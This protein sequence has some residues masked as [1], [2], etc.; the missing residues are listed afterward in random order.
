MRLAIEV[1][2]ARARVEQE[3]DV[4]RILP[5][6]VAVPHER[7]GRTARRA[8]RE[9]LDVLG[10]GSGSFEVRRELRCLGARPRLERHLTI[11]RIAD[12]ARR[13]LRG[14]AGPRGRARGGPSSG[15]PPCGS[16]KLLWL[17]IVFDQC[18]WTSGCPSGSRAPV[19]SPG[20]DHHARVRSRNC[21][22]P[23]AS[24]ERRRQDERQ[25]AAPAARRRV[26]SMTVCISGSCGP[27]AA[28]RRRLRHR[29][30]TCRSRACSSSSRSAGS[31][32]RDADAAAR[33]ASTAAC[34]P[35]GSSS[36][37]R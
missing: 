17:P 32:A 26:R 3:H 20:R 36:V 23:C 28:R 35:S 22:A 21:A 11:G 9:R 24:D 2:D 12:A 29:V 4:A 33:S 5:D 34:R 19:H 18:P 8:A 10:P 6:L 30:V 31:S 1:D 25:R 37:A 27:L 16:V 15:P 14:A 13:A 7:L